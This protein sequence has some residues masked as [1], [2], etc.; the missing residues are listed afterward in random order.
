MRKAFVVSGLVLVSLLGI[1]C[2]ALLTVL[3]IRSGVYAADCQT[4]FDE[5][6]L[7]RDY[8][9]E[10]VEADRQAAQEE[11][12]AFQRAKDEQ[13]AITEDLHGKYHE[14][15]K[16]LE[17]EG[18]ELLY[19]RLIR[20]RREDWLVVADSI[21]TSATKDL[22]LLF[23][24]LTFTDGFYFC[25]KALMGGITEM[26]DASGNKQSFLFAEWKDLR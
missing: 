9:T 21:Q 6:C 17:K 20:V 4:S 13:A 14:G 24:T 11:S 22:P 5:S 8:D 23:S 15:S 3:L 18:Y 16:Y 2:I 10:Q 12:E 19:L 7:S 1:A 26:I 25:K